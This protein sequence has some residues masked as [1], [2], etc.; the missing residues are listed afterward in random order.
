MTPDPNRF[1]SW[2]HAS[3]AEF[4]R[5]SED[6]DRRQRDEIAKLQ[7]K[8]AKL[9]RFKDWVHQYLDDR[10]VPHHPPGTHGAEGCRIGDRM[11]WLMARIERLKAEL[12][13][14]VR[15][16]DAHELE[17]LQCDGIPEEAWCDCLQKQVKRAKAVLEA[18]KR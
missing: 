6:A 15:I 5:K 13:G 8:V 17:S 7:T 1:S 9:Q 2:S 3:L 14:L 16:I 10:G 12:D 4:A 18:G 11:D